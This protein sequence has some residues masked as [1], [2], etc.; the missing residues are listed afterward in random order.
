MTQTLAPAD[1]SHYYQR[2]AELSTL[3]FWQLPDITDPAGP[4]H[5]HV[6]H[7]QHIHPELT[8]TRQILDDA[9]ALQRRA[10]V[11]R[12][13]G[14]PPP[15]AGAT[16]TLAASHQMLFPDETAPVHAH[17]MSALRFG[18]AGRGARMVIDGDRV[19]LEPGD[20][21]LTPG[22]SW[23]G[24]VHPGG[25]EPVVWLDGLDAPFV[26]GLRAGFYRDDP[27]AGNPLPTQDTPGTALSPATL[28]PAD[29][30]AGRHSPVRRYPWQE[31]YPALQR[32]MARAPE[33]SPL[34]RLEYRNPI[35]G[36]P[37][38]ATIACL[39]E[40]LPAGARTRSS[41]QTASSVLVVARGTGTL[42]CAGQAF[43]LLPNDVAAI[44]AWT[45]HQL[46]AHDELVIFRMTDRPIHD[47]FGLF[48]AEA[49]DSAT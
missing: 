6:W 34:T 15:A 12:N 23:H 29:D 39:L 8:R 42:S 43:E 14:L 40:G 11:L 47:A 7:W 25:S 21:V 22:W 16:P 26:M 32:L 41:R 9:V 20:L 2:L 48:R 24:H 36:G 49:T 38:L 30:G 10:L 1:V 28:G 27:H 18:L 46:T 5:G 37:A 19:P 17:S 4:E 45:W 13:P 44:P 35:T 33:H 3:P 31:A